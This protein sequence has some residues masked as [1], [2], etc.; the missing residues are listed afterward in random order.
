M[1]I[2]MTSCPYCGNGHNTPCFAV[3]DDGYKCFSCGKFK[4][5]DRG[6]VQKDANKSSNTRIPST[7][8][9]L[10]TWSEES[11]LYLYNYH[12]NNT[13]IKRYGIG[14]KEPGVLIY[15][16]FDKNKFICYIER[17]INPKRV[18]QIGGKQ[19][20]IIDKVP[21]KSVVIV[22]D[23]ISAVRI[24]EVCPTLCLFGTK[25]KSDSLKALVQDYEEII[26]WLDGDEA[27][28]KAADQLQ[29]M[30]TMYVSQ[31]KNKRSFEDP[32]RKIRRIQTSKDPKCYEESDLIKHIF[33]E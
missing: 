28:Q 18:K 8:L 32:Y 30:L 1:L 23:W 20:V 17:T 2:E 15:P 11:L 19:A 14:E 4:K 5:A 13:L 24:G 9:N 10:S 6:F 29:Y 25:C 26:L 3:Y 12:F 22:E 27:G 7:N 33:E 21:A 16:V 31:Y